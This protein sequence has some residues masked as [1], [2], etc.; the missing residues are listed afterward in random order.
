MILTIDSSLNYYWNPI[1]L[2][3]VFDFCKFVCKSFHDTFYYRE[4]LIAHFRLIHSLRMYLVV[5]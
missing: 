3:K 2:I 4:E 1:L 5:F